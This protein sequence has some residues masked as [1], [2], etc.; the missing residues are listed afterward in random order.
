M[1]QMLISGYT[2]PRASLDLIRGVAQPVPFMVLAVLL[3]YLIKVISFGVMGALPAPSERPLVAF[4]VRGLLVHAAQFFV[5]ATVIFWGTRLANG[6]AT[7][8]ETMLM[9]SWYILVVSFLTPLMVGLSDGLQG[10]LQTMQDGGEVQISPLVI[11]LAFAVSALQIW[12]LAVNVATLNGF[13]K[14]WTVIGAVIGAQ[15]LV[16][17]FFLMVGLDPT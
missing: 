12:L 6:P 8:L 16:G 5:M 10:A 3:A 7:R 17:I 2:H 11:L 9:M 14:I 13:T 4:H 1:I 15:I